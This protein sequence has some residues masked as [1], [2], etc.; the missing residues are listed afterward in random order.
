MVE[1]NRQDL[2]YRII[3]RIGGEMVRTKADPRLAAAV[4]ENLVTE[5]ARGSKVKQKISLP[6]QWVFR[7]IGRKKDAKG[8]PGTSTIPADVGKLIT[9]LA[10]GVNESRAKGTPLESGDK[11]EAIDALLRNLDLGEIL[12]MVEG[13]DPHVLESIRTVNEQLWKYPAK[14]GTLSVM[15]IVLVNTSI[16]AFR[17]I[18]R[19]I[20]EQFSPD[21]LAD[22]ILST[23]RDING[24]NTGT[25]VNTAYE[26]IRRIH[27]G[28]LRLGEG[29]K[30]LFQVYLTGFLKNY[31]PAMD[32]GLMKKIRICLA[33]DAE[34]IANAV[35]EAWDA[36]PNVVL[37]A[38]SSLGEIQNCRAR[39]KTRK[40]QVLEDIETPGFNTAVSESVSSLDTYEV[41]GLVN[42]LCRVIDRVHDAKPDIV[43]NLVGGIVDSVDAEQV[44]RIVRWLVTDLVEAIRPLAPVVVPELVKGLQELANEEESGGISISTASGG[45]K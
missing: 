30:P 10:A 43:R 41:A 4:A 6:V 29:G 9:L 8:T 11:G 13:A 26:L 37:S 33:E 39:G 42:T 21:L 2:I 3:G 32:P 34:A 36:N 22:L 35:S 27:T 45:E 1:N 17:E 19:P 5:W 40:L 23:I 14:V 44:R 20:E 38:L 25:L 15:A 18:I 28:S 31:F 24:A 16:K 7:K 12:E